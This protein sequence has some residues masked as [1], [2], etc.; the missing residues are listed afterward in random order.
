METGDLAYLGPGSTSLRLRNPAEHPARVLLLGG[1][2]FGEDLLMWW[3]FVARTHDEIVEYRR[4]WQDGD[5]R[6]GA[7]N[8]YSGAVPRLPAPPLPT[9]GLRPRHRRS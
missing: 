6:F 2:P 1:P 7:V 9:T 5:A 3:N 4:L 8:G